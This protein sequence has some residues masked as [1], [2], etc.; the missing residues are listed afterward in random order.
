MEKIK[1]MALLVPEI[2]VGVGGRRDGVEESAPPTGLL[3][4]ISRIE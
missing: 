2:S 1:V 4:K 3:E